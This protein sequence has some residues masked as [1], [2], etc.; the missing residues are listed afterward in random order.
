MNISRKTSLVRG[1]SLAVPGI[2]PQ[3]YI[4]KLGVRKLRRSLKPIEAPGFNLLRML[5]YPTPCTEVSPHCHPLWE[6][7]GSF[8]LTSQ[9]RL[10][11]STN[12]VLLTIGAAEFKINLE[13]RTS[14]WG[15]NALQDLLCFLSWTWNSD[16]LEEQ[17]CRLV[18]ATP[19]DP[20]IVLILQSQACQF[21]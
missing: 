3:P 13:F 17:F 10:Q 15:S 1:C 20:L 7:C 6:W 19:G 2:D 8:P 5:G 14:D 12:I 16:S 18:G 21:Q 4:A 9:Q 11:G